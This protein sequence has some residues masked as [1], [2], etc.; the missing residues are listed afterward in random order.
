MLRI[1]S[2]L[3][4]LTACAVAN[5]QNISPSDSP[6]RAHFSYIKGNANLDIGPN[7]AEVAG[8]SMLTTLNYKFAEKF[9]AEAGYG[10]SSADSMSING[11]SAALD[12]NSTTTTMLGLGYLRPKSNKIGQY[13]GVGYQTVSS[14]DPDEDGSNILKILSQ[15]NT[16]QRFGEVSFQRASSE[17]GS[18]NSLAGTHIWFIQPGLGLGFE[19]ALSGAKLDAEAFG[20]EGEL[21]EQAAGIVFMYRP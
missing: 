6:L 15:K 2:T 21:T 8:T 5:A 18:I 1:A 3:V 7:S 9:Y 14:D 10:K 20:A 12:D 4:L 19:W 11:A 16:S 17:S 13:W